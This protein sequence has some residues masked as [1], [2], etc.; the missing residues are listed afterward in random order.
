MSQVF[1][2]KSTADYLEIHESICKKVLLIYRQLGLDN[3]DEIIWYSLFLA[4]LFCFL[5][6]SLSHLFPFLSFLFLAFLFCSPFPFSF[7]TFP[8]SSLSPSL[9][10]F[11]PFALFYSLLF[12]LPFLFPSAFH[13]SLSSTSFP[14]YFSCFVVLSFPWFIPA[15]RFVCQ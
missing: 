8:I 3:T 9:T 13:P 11:A 4:F 7:T 2:S 14:V 15:N 5:F 1:Y 10:S 12:S 6:Y